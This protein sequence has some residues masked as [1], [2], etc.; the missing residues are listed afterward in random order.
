M[1][2]APLVPP[3]AVAHWLRELPTPIAVTGG[4]GFVGSHVV[5]TLCAAGL[6]PKVLVR[7]AAAPRWIA[8]APADLVLGS[9]E[10][11]GS[12]A[13]AVEGAGTVLHLAGR[14]TSDSAAAFDEANRGGTERLVEA[15][16]TVA[17]DAR[18]VHVSSLA[19]VGPSAERSGVGPEA[20]PAPISDYGRSKLAGERAVAALGDA[21]WWAIVRPPAIYGPRDTDVFEFFRMA[22]RGV[23]V[24]PA[25][26]RWVTIAHVADV[27]RGILAAAAVGV[28]RR[29]LHLGEPEPRRLDRMLVELAAAGG[30]KV[31]LIPVPAAAVRAVGAASGALRRLGLVDSALTSDK[32]RELVARHWSART[33]DSLEALGLGPQVTLPEG[34][35]ETWAWYRQQGWLR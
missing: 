17:R 35:R 18:L 1:S 33:V 7:D 23:A 16:R 2:A 13:R 27:V 32:A 14:V 19:A 21:A 11:A 31:R 8:G 12:L 6:R 25:G 28:H 20:R 5:D 34:A 3:D 29:V 4:T 26:E 24:L 9:L 30:R 10:D 15:V 22:Q